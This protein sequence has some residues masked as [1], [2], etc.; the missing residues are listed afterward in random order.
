[1]DLWASSHTNEKNLEQIR[2]NN[3][4]FDDWQDFQNSSPQQTTLQISSDA[5][6]FDITSAA[7]PDAFGGL[8]FGGALQLAASE[9]LKDKKEASN[10]AKTSPSDDHLKRL[11]V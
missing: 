7:W 10:E 2:E 8:E 1:M 3:D 5:A 4:L 9:N 6:L 11:V